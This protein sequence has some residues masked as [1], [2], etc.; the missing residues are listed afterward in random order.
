MTSPK[1]DDN[2]SKKRKFDAAST[3]APPAL[4]PANAQIVVAGPLT[5]VAREERMEEA[6]APVSELVP[7]RY[8][9][10]AGET[11][12][13]FAMSMQNVGELGYM[14][15]PLNQLMANRTYELAPTIIRQRLT[16]VLTS[17]LTLL[18]RERGNL[19]IAASAATAATYATLTADGCMS[20]LYGRLRNIHKATG[21]NPTRYTSPP[22]YNKTYELP[23]PFALAIEGIGVFVLD[24][25]QNK[26]LIVPTYPENTRNEGRSADTWNTTQYVTAVANMKAHGI[27]FKKIDLH[28]QSGNPWW[29]FK[30]VYNHTAFDLKCIFPP[31]MYTLLANTIATMFLSR[32]EGAAVQILTHKDDDVDYPRRARDIDPQEVAKAFFALCHFPKMY[33][34]SVTVT[35]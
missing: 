23:L 30:S 10:L 32:A 12:P 28:Q 3:S 31:T 33:H 5:D 7:V 15:A 2:P 21:V 9:R 6:A 18:F 26:R 4:D 27:P 29:T 1:K 17:V 8:E 14:K 13:G 19:S 35:A 22:I 24:D 25:V 20:A 11:K 34:T 16:A